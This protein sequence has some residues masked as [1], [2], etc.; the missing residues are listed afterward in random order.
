MK[1]EI[2]QPLHELSKLYINGDGE[3]KSDAWTVICG[4]AGIERDDIVF[5]VYFLTYCL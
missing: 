2:R 1:G 5:N 3:V 4:V